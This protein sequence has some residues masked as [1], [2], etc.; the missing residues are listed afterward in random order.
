MDEFKE[1]KFS[2]E[3]IF[4][5]ALLCLL[6]GQSPTGPKNTLMVT[7]SHTHTHNKVHALTLKYIIYA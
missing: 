2:L 4:F 3:V 5:L 7:R 6:L 1:R